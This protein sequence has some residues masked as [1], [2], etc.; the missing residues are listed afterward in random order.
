M[1]SAAKRRRLV[2]KQKAEHFDR[3][4]PENNDLIIVEPQAGP[5][6]RHHLQAARHGL[7]P[8]TFRRML[9]FGL[10]ISLFNLIWFCT[11][12]GSHDDSLDYIEFFSGV[13]NV[14]KA[15]AEHG[16]ASVAFDTVNDAHRQDFLSRAGILTC[17]QW[18]RRLRCRGGTHWATV[19]SS[20]VWMNRGTARRHVDFPLGWEPRSDVVQ[21]ANRM[22]ALMAMYLLWLIAK[23][24]SWILEQPSSSLMTLHPRLVEVRNVVGRAWVEVSTCM[25][26]FGAATVK[27]SK[28][29]SSSSWA[30][31]LARSLSKTQRQQL[32]VG[33]EVTKI[34]EI[35]GGVS[36]GRDLKGT[37]E[38]PNAYGYAVV[39][40]FERDQQEILIE[41]ASESD[42]E[43]EFENLISMDRDPWDDTGI[44]EVCVWLGIP[45]DR[46]I[47]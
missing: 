32:G 7:D 4:K 15:F 40:A 26:A 27:S 43:A 25:G 11:Q 38:Y 37:Q 30:K 47:V 20:W 12:H 29:W 23:D 33:K 42:S 10:P 39:N 18:L 31:D 34:D 45:H 28:L 16:H 9:R 21:A 1:Q 22:V 24:C 2:S 17:V 35:T 5:T 3:P 13:G 41:T 44:S 46:W 19:C 36:A 8:R 6:K 14:Q